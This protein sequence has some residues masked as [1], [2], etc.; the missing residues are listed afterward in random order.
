MFSALSDYNDKNIIRF[1]ILDNL[2]LNEYV[3]AEPNTEEGGVIARIHSPTDTTKTY[4]IFHWTIKFVRETWRTE[5][6]FTLQSVV[7]TGK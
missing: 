4:I 6:F 1:K 2:E 7:D 5:H 3:T